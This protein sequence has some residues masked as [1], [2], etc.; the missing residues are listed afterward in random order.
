MTVNDILQITEYGS[1]IR[2]YDSPSNTTSIEGYLLRANYD[3]FA[4]FGDKTLICINTNDETLNFEL[5]VK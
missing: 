1:H 4:K 3:D 2:I 5:V